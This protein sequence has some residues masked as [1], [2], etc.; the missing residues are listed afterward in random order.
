LYDGVLYAEQLRKPGLQHGFLPVDDAIDPG[1][2]V[3]GLEFDAG[4]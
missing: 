1:G 2:R 3:R 4:F